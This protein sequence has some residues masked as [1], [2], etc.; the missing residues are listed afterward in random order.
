MLFRLSVKILNRS[1]QGLLSTARCAAWVC[2]AAPSPTS[3]HGEQERPGKG[4]DLPC[5]AP[6]AAASHR[7]QRPHS[8]PSKVWGSLSAAAG[9]SGRLVW[10]IFCLGFFVSSSSSVSLS[11]TWTTTLGVDSVPAW[12]SYFSP[13]EVSGRKRSLSPETLFYSYFKCWLLAFK[14]YIRALYLALAFKVLIQFCP[15]KKLAGEEPWGRELNGKANDCS[16]D[17]RSEPAS[18]RNGSSFPSGDTCGVPGSNLHYRTSHIHD[19]ALMSKNTAKPA[20]RRMP[21]ASLSK[22]HM[23]I[24]GE[25]LVWTS[26]AL[27]S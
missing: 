21:L 25:Q 11:Q 15:L 7:T 9:G 2:V 18:L 27:N 16:R 1:N 14:S 3:T 26:R 13:R 23:V 6:G 17:G 19:I 24:A 22:R 4:A 5:G 10:V 8:S 20:P 12:S